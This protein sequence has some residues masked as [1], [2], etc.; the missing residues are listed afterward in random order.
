[1]LGPRNVQ[2]VPKTPLIKGVNPSLYAQVD[3]N[4]EQGDLYVH[5]LLD[6]LAGRKTGSR[7]CGDVL[8]D[9]NR[10]PRNFKY[11]SGY[12]VQ[13]CRVQFLLLF[14]ITPEGSATQQVQLHKIQNKNNKTVKNT[15]VKY[16]KLSYNVKPSYNCDRLGE[17][18]P[19]GH[20]FL[21]PSYCPSSN[22]VRAAICNKLY[23][24]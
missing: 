24:N 17:T 23:S 21:C 16:R 12:V 8:V 5:R 1:M 4:V 6:V 9:E 20:F 19:D 3:W 13:V 18:N 15:H 2:Y 22:T 10:Q 11:M 7:V 14:F